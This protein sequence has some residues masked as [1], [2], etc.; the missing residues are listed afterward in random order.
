MWKNLHFYSCHA[1]VLFIRLTTAIRVGSAKARS[2]AVFI[3]GRGEAKTAGIDTY[4]HC[5]LDAGK[6]VTLDCKST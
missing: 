3:E 1:I 6:H 5:S 2:W 4:E